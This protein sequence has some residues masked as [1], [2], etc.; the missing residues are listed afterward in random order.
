MALVRDM[1]LILLH[2]FGAPQAPALLSH[3]VALRGSTLV[4]SGFLK[5]IFELQA[6]RVQEIKSEAKASKRRREGV[7]PKTTCRDRIC[8]G[9]EADDARLT[10]K[11]VLTFHLEK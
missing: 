2:A 9:C 3:F 5:E 10:G 11:S 6:E 1:T 8:I 4:A 7:K